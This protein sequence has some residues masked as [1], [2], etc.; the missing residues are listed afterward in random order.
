MLNPEERVSEMNTAT[1]EAR[2]TAQVLTLDLRGKTPDEVVDILTENGYSGVRHYESDVEKNPSR[3][4]P[5]PSERDKTR[6]VICV[7]IKDE[8]APNLTVV[9]YDGKAH[10][11]CPGHELYLYDEPDGGWGWARTSDYCE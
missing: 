6:V 10:N 9:A 2:G 3:F 8:E 4:N 5:D 7:T 1:A 11:L